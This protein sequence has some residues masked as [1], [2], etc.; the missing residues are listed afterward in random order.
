MVEIDK[1]NKKIIKIKPDILLTSQKTKETNS[2][3]KKASEFLINIWTKISGNS[4]LPETKII[5]DNS[6]MVS[7]PVCVNKNN[8]EKIMDRTYIPLELS[9]KFKKKM[10]KIKPQ[11]KIYTNCEINNA[12]PAKECIK[13]IKENIENDTYLEDEGFYYQEDTEMKNILKTPKKERVDLPNTRI[14]SGLSSAISEDKFAYT[15]TET[16][17]GNHLNNEIIQRSPEMPKMPK[18]EIPKIEERKIE[19][20]N[21]PKIDTIIDT[22]Q[23]K[24]T[25][26]Q[27]SENIASSMSDDIAQSSNKLITSLPFTT[28]AEIN[29][30]TNLL[31]LQ[32]PL[33][34]PS[35]NPILIPQPIPATIPMPS[36]FLTS[37][38]ATTALIPQAPVNWSSVVFF[39]L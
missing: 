24:D 32:A 22:A 27:F 29:L 34:Q 26:A 8:D 13:N 9:K 30:P 31:G 12:I 6:Q 10:H 3:L 21:L 33:P 18:I 28:A 35:P 20:P 37:L 14:S 4:Q 11:R 23:K 17:P 16:D 1:I 15:E 5:P 39:F 19:I 25:P 36:G 38:S 2:L 7:L